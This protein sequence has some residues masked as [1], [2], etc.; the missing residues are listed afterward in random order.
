MLEDLFYALGVLDERNDAHRPLTLGAGE[1]VNLVDF[2]DE[3]CPVLAVS[4]KRTY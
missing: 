1:G 4:F 2:L 3:P